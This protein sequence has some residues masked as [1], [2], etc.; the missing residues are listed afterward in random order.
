VIYQ[1]NITQVS[2]PTN[3]ENSSLITIDVPPDVM[4]HY[5]FQWRHDAGSTDVKR[6]WLKPTAMTDAACSVSN[7]THSNRR[8]GSNNQVFMWEVET[9]V[10]SSSQIRSR[11]DNTSNGNRFIYTTGFR[12]IR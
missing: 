8:T 6:V 4:A 7:F 3:S 10:D 1:D 9:E 11:F 12:F 2:V 5:N